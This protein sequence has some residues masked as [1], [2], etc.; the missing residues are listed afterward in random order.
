M[1]RSVLLYDITF[2]IYEGAKCVTVIVF[3]DGISVLSNPVCILH[4]ANF[5]RERHES[6]YS[7][8]S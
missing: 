1:E 3:R 5:T 4:N 7:L 6:N 8:S 2:Q